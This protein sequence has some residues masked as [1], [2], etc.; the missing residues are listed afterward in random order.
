M[1]GKRTPPAKAAQAVALA[2]VHGVDVAAKRTG[3]AERTIRRLRDDPALAEL[4]LRAREAVLADFWITIQVG[5]DEIHAGLTGEAPLRDKA[6]TLAV[7]VD[8]YALLS[9]EAT[10]RT[11]HREL[12]INPTEPDLERARDAYVAA[13]SRGPLVV[14]EGAGQGPASNGHAVLRA[15]PLPTQAAD[16]YLP[17][18]AH[19]EGPTNGHQPDGGHRG[20]LAS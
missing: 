3:V 16:G 17:A 18:T 5:I 15:V 10:A 9:G 8:R 20:P 19:P 12:D 2:L 6:Q 14:G 1:R 13:L 4:G 7:L 11:E